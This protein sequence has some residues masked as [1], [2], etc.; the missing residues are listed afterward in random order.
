MMRGDM[1]DTIDYLHTTASDRIII[2]YTTDR[3]VFESG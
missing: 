3:T 2:T 1:T